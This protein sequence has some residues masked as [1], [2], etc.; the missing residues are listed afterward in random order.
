MAV[1]LAFMPDAATLTVGLANPWPTLIQRF[2]VE[3]QRHSGSER[4]VESYGRLLRSFATRVAQPP[5][6]VASAD[7]FEFVYHVGPSRRRPTTATVSARLTCSSSFYQFLRRLGHVA[8]NP[9]DAVARPKVRPATPRGLSAGEV[10]R[11]LAAVPTTPV[12]L[13]DRAIVITLVMTGRRRAEVL[14]LRASDLEGAGAGIYYRYRGKGGK[15]GRRELPPPVL[16]AIERCLAARGTSL[17]Q[18]PADAP[19][20]QA[21]SGRSNQALSAGTFAVNFRRYLGMA[22]LEPTGVHVLRH[23]A[24][25]L[26]REVGATVEDIASFLDHTSLAVTTT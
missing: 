12:G 17:A 10:R 4:T 23:T 9:C 5:A 19:L 15:R 26:R 14:R 8:A 20:W 18:L 24:A 2:L 25:K 1:F 6:Q 3:K 21:T 16:R 13:R 11:L 7:V 22:G